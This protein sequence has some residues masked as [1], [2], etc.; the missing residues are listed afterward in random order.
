MN[1]PKQTSR[2]IEHYKSIIDMIQAGVNLIDKDGKII[3]VNDSYCKMHG[4][5]KEELIGK[6]LDLI[7]PEQN[8]DETLK[9]YKKI[10]NKEIDKPYTL[11]GVNVR[12]DGSTFPVII[13]WNQL[14]KD[15]VL[16]GMVTVIQ[17]LTKIKAV[18]KALD[19]SEKK[20]KYLTENIKELKSKLQKREYL[21]YIMGDSISI[22]AV[23][24]AVERVGQTDFSVI[25]TGETGTGKEIIAN[26]IHSFSNRENKPL[27]SID[28]GAIPETLI[29]SE[30]FGSV[31]GAFTGANETKDGA[32]QEAN[33]GSIFLDEITN[34]SLEMQKKLLRVL[35]EKVVSKVGSTQKEKLDIRIIA[36]S[37]EDILKL[38][39]TGKFRKDLYFRLNEFSIS[40]PPLRSRPDDIPILVQRFSEE[41]SEQ[42]KTERNITKEAMRVLCEYKW[43]G[44]V[45][46]LK[47]I[48]KK[49][50]IISEKEINPEHFDFIEAND[51]NVENLDNMDLINNLDY[52]NIDLKRTVKEYSG[53]IEKRIIEKTIGKF[54]GNKSKSAKFLNIDYKTILQ[55]IKDYDINH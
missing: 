51:S 1:R 17:D 46:E 44:N 18:E 45:R 36:A 3:Y 20:N 34:L 31:K 22:I 13:S 30:L 11:E 8:R 40:L 27:I 48:I 6:S 12:S 29:E 7:M 53:K 54:K 5:K 42:L 21:E 32:F 24:K 50:Y 14:L 2:I 15:G 23:H 10:I 43:P 28:C 39:D 52:S 49:A 35:Q 37:N 16:D 4:Y 9:Q 55:K 33:G 26:A 47:N 25:I 19:D 38:V 41:V